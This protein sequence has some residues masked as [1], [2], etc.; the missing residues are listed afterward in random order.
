M[1]SALK[2]VRKRFFADPAISLN[3]KAQVAQTLILARGL[4]NSGVWPA[5]NKTEFHSVHSSLMRVY[6]AIFTDIYSTEW[7]SDQNLLKRCELMAPCNLLRMQRLLL[8]VRVARRGRPCLYLALVA[9]WSLKESWLKAVM[10]DLHW[11]SSRHNMFLDS[12]DLFWWVSICQKNPKR[13]S[14]VFRSVLC[15]EENNQVSAWRVAG[16]GSVGPCVFA[17]EFCS[18]RFSSKQALA[19]HQYKVH[20]CVSG[21]KQKVTTAHCECCLQYFGS[22]T[23]VFNHLYRSPRCS[24]F[25][26]VHVVVPC[27]AEVFGEMWAEELK[28]HRK[29]RAKGYKHHKALVPVMRARTRPI[30]RVP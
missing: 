4:Y 24:M 3:R 19:V 29:L 26:N 20:S 8:F 17:C 15:L 16:V 11:M 13:V 18:G 6:R 2:G 14:D 23:R 7:E 9:A 5:L 25:Y 21:L 1:S 22:L 10:D 30:L 27:G 28:G 12:G